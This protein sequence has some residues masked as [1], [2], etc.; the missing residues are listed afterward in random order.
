MAGGEGTRGEK[1]RTVLEGNMESSGGRERESRRGKHYRKGRESRCVRTKR[2]GKQRKERGTQ[3]RVDTHC[4]IELKDR[5]DP[6][7]AS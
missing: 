5:S 6:L 1:L 3:R 4:S 2:E 7:L